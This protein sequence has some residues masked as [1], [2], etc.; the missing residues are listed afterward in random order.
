MLGVRTADT[1]GT[2]ATSRSFTNNCYVDLGVP[3]LVHA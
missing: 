3:V 2:N 1:L